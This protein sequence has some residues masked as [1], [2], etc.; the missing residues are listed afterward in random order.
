LRLPTVR[1]TWEEMHRTPAAEA[2]RLKAII[3]A[4]S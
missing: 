4:W 3:A 1:I 2:T